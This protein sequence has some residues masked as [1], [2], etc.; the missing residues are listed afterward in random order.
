MSVFRLKEGDMEILNSLLGLVRIHLTK[1]RM[2]SFRHERRYVHLG[3]EIW[4][5][6]LKGRD[7]LKRSRL[8]FSLRHSLSVTIALSVMLSA[9]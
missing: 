8:D 1:E 7:I 6:L 9:L 4:P 2:N 3:D 5:H